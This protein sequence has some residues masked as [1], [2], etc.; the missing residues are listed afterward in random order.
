MSKKPV[1]VLI[2]DTHL[3]LKTIDVNRSVW[4]QADELAQELDVP[5]FH[6]GDILESRKSQPQEVFNVLDDIISKTKSN[7]YSIV[8]NHDKTDTKL[9][10]SFLDQFRHFPNFNLIEH[11]NTQ[12]FNNIGVCFLSFFDEKINYLDFLE[13]LIRFDEKFK[14]GS[15]KILITHCAIEGVKNNDG[16]VV[17]EGGVKQLFFNKFDKVLV[18]HYHDYQKISDKII[19]VGAAYQANFGEDER[20]GATIIYD[21]ATIE[22]HPFEFP[23]YNNIQ[24]SSEQ[25]LLEFIE[26][27]EPDENYY[28]VNGYLDYESDILFYRKKLKSLG[29]QEN[30]SVRYKAGS[31]ESQEEY[32]VISNKEIVDKFKSWSQ[33]K[34]IDLKN[35]KSILEQWET[36]MI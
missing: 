15:S 35:Q 4:R 20:K 36:T 30:I 10:D 26:S 7:I 28:K 31:N 1:G 5:I 8:G 19:Y 18:G 32:Q 29:V 17:Q 16:S 24:V 22:F 6:G 14:N 9:E 11:I 27:F 12:T 13:D 3:S 33:E 23:T 21:D 2:T 25:D 34:S